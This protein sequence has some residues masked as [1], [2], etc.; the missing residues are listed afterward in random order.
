MALFDKKVQLVHEYEVQEETCTDEQDVPEHPVF[1]EELVE[2]MS[3]VEHE[4]FHAV[5]SFLHYVLG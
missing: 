5:N 2:D 1:H 3:V 4:V